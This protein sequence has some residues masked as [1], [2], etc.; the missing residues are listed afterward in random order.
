M[1]CRKCGKEV[2]GDMEF[3]EACQATH[4]DNNNRLSQ[5]ST[6]EPSQNPHRHTGK[7]CCPK[8]KSKNLQIV[9]NTNYT[10]QT[11]GGGYSAANGCCGYMALG[12][13]GLLCGSCGSTQSTTVTSTNTSVWVCLDCGNKFRDI[14]DIEED[15]K[16][17]S[18]AHSGYYSIGSIFI[19]L[20]LICFILFAFADSGMELSLL[21][22]VS[23]GIPGIILLIIGKI[24]KADSDTKLI[25]LIKEK[26]NIQKNGYSNE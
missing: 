11:S 2:I 16:K 24:I 20:S 19:V 21:S 26:E 12:P 15:I 7:K 3:C 6:L 23:F 1:F 10:S 13:L 14:S 18:T 4:N 5:N 9:T 8:C 25:A 22:F 17:T